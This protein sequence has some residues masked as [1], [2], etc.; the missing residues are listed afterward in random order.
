MPRR[1]L[2]TG[3]SRGIG[4]ELASQYA[5]DGWETWATH[6]RREVDAALRDLRARLPDR[7]RLQHLDVGSEPSVHRAAA[8]LGERSLDLLIH[9]AGTANRA[10]SLLE[11][12]YEAWERA[13]RVNAWGALAVARALLGPL[14]EGR[15]R[16]IVVGSQMGSISQVDGGGRY[17][18]RASKAAANMV[19]RTLARDLEA[20]GVTVASIHPGWVRT[21]LGGRAAPLSARESVTNI[22]RTISTLSLPRTGRFFNYD[23]EELPW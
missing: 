7:V 9:N 13:M 4:L 16:F 1:V 5:V 17:A 3:T 15:G 10:G 12:T 21:R 18:Y 14:V 22:R 8:V 19:V 23:G 6:R 2:I 20:E 11:T